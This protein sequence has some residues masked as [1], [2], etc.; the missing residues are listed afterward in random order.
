MP[1]PIKHD[2][3]TVDK[4]SFPYIL[5]QNVTVTPK[6]VRK[7]GLI[8]YNVFRPKTTDRVPV[9]MTY[10]PYGKDTHTSEFLPH[11]YEDI[12]PKQKSEH[13]C[14]EVPDPK[15]WTSQGFAV[16]RADEIGSGQSPGFLDPM[17]AQ[18]SDAFAELI[19]WAADQPWSTG[20]VGLLGI[21]YYA[22]SQW[23]VAA[24]RPRGLACIIPYE[25]MADYYRDRCRH[26]GILLEPFLQFW[27]GKHARLNQYGFPG[28]SKIQRGPD[29]IEGDL[30][31]E[32]LK[33]N[34]ADQD[35]D[36][37]HAFFRDDEYYA[38]RDYNLE[39]IE[40]PVLSFGNWSNIVV[41]LRGNIEGYK[42]AG[43]RYKFL[44]I[45]SG[46]HDLPFY[47]DTEIEAQRS[48]LFAFLKDDDYAGWTE[49]RQPKITYQ[50]RKGPF[51]YKSLKSATGE[52]YSWRS[53]P[54]WPLPSTKYTN[55]YLSPDLTWS[56]QV[57]AVEFH[58]RLS[59]PAMS[60][61]KDQF[62]HR[63][64]TAPFEKET[65]I[66]GHIVAHV[67]VSVTRTPGGTVPKDIDVF[68]VVRQWDAEGNERVFTGTIGDAAAL[69]RGC[70]RVSLR[71]V[72][73][74]HPH[75]REYRAHRDYFST[76]V[77]PVIPGE[78]YP[79]DIEIWPTNVVLLPGERI[80][81][82]ISGGDTGGLGPF[83]HEGGERTHERFGGMNHLHFGPNYLNY[84]TLPII[85]S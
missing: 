82:E 7:G 43:S 75:H 52:I 54:E 46:R 17:S 14:F 61:T 62:F 74:E 50:A 81:V 49:G 20:R 6:T 66:T 16:V 2:I 71:K 10:G 85:Y 57:P 11:S 58:E 51:D 60:T 33:E 32:E 24:R 35:I 40:V 23:R 48:F 25:G 22:G 83:T 47:S 45:G 67:N 5:E 18:T 69:T 73:K 4:V 27:M 21:S 28:R 39:D 3:L 31:A 42:L 79:V 9:I 55:Y 12:N 29:T 70:Q 38:S 15:Y 53:G 84:I 77:L 36:N 65:E 76:D 64:T 78:V 80:S 30:S 13:A 44:R 34:R 68:V 41:H 72:N 56:P 63:F 37:L 8:R 19:E 1:N 26:G 59:Y